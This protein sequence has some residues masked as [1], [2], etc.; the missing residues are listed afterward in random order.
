MDRHVDGLDADDGGRR[1]RD[2]G[3]VQRHQQ[4]R[5][6]GR[7]ANTPR[8]VGDCVA[9][10]QLD[11]SV[12]HEAAAVELDAAR[13]TPWGVDGGQGNMRSTSQVAHE[14]ICDEAPLGPRELVE[15]DASNLHLE[16]GD[17]NARTRDGACVFGPIC[18]AVMDAARRIGLPIGEPEATRHSRAP[19]LAL[20]D[21]IGSRSRL[22]PVHRREVHNA[23]AE[24]GSHVRQVYSLH[25][26]KAV[27]GAATWHRRVLW[28]SAQRC[29]VH[30][31][32]AS[33]APCLNLVATCLAT[34][35]ACVAGVVSDASVTRVARGSR[36]RGRARGRARRRRRGCGHAR[37]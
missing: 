10:R 25:L 14:V 31:V 32:V 8:D 30:P 33:H 20:G 1:V 35:V 29:D 23:V 7:F 22:V 9:G 4:L 18:Q 5:A 2:V 17:A 34:R 26:G 11:V 16:V 12:G 28:Q 19:G 6:H 24:A 37:R 15:V 27:G 36:A 21:T 3:V 13:G